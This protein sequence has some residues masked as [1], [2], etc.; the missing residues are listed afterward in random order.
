MLVRANSL[1][2]AF[3]EVLTSAQMNAIDINVTNAIDGDGGGTYAPSSPLDVSNLRNVEWGNGYWPAQTSRDEWRTLS[4][5]RL[6]SVGGSWN[7]AAGRWDQINDS[8]E[9]YF[10]GDNLV[11]G[12]QLVG[13]RLW[14]TG[15]GGHAALPATMPHLYVVKVKGD[16]TTSSL[17]DTVDASGTTA[18]YQ[19][20]H[21]INVSFSMDGALDESAGVRYVLHLIGEGGANF[22]AGMRVES[23][24]LRFV[25]ATNRPG[26]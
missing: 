8:D 23:A 13:A 21:Q 22:V 11:A 10:A 6:S 20:I 2:W 25:C 15:A 14:L 3:L 1:G 17:G 26:G 12:A 4:L 18:V 19:A 24:A 9:I 16:G 7:F 5:N